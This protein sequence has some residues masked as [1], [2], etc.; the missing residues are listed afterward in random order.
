MQQNKTTLHCETDSCL[1]LTQPFTHDTLQWLLREHV[2]TLGVIAAYVVIKLLLRVIGRLVL[3][4]EQCSSTADVSARVWDPVCLLHNLVSIAVGL[5]TVVTWDGGGH[6]RRLLLKP[7]AAPC[8]DNFGRQRARSQ[9]P[10]AT[11]CWALA[12]H[13]TSFSQPGHIRQ[14]AVVPRWPEEPLA[15]LSWASSPWHRRQSHGHLRPGTWSPVSPSKLTSI[16]RQ[17]RACLPDERRLNGEGQGTTRLVA[18][19][20]GRLRRR[21]RAEE[22][23]CPVFAS[24][25]A[26]ADRYDS[27]CYRVTRCETGHS[28]C[29]AAH[30][31]TRAVVCCDCTAAESGRAFFRRL[32]STQPAPLLADMRSVEVFVGLSR[33]RRSVLGASRRH[34]WAGAKR[35]RCDV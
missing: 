18:D 9:T 6:H 23:R 3:G 28:C 8:N 13:R 1:D 33:A 5:Y 17:R 30:W 20:C 25:A 35:S 26:S 34:A 10:H 22:D 15:Q 16:A 31:R 11:W 7:A 2:V 12:Q 24:R 14:R 4:A 27:T 19:A 21:C 32:G 29:R